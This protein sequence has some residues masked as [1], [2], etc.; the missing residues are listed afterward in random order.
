[1]FAYIDNVTV[2]GLNLSDH[3][4]SANSVI[5]CLYFL[6]TL[7]GAVFCICSDLGTMFKSEQLRQFLLGQGVAVSRTTQYISQGNV[8]NTMVLF[9]KPFNWLLRIESAQLLIGKTSFQNL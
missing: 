2:C 7:F 9:R 1:M 6:F 3:D 4:T 8:K 5:K